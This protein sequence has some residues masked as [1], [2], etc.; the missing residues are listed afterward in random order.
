M[1]LPHLEEI[2]KQIQFKLE[3]EIEKNL[4]DRIILSETD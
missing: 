2:E 1:D 3:R 4:Q